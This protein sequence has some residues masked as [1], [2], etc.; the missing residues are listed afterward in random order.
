L[1]E[2]KKL[3]KIMLHIR[4]SH[5]NGHLNGEISLPGS[6][7]I[8]NRALVMA[9]LAQTQSVEINGLSTALDTVLMQANLA[10][11]GTGLF[12]AGDAGT[13]FRFLVARL[14]IC[15]GKHILQ[16]SD[17]MHERPIGPLV[18]ALR[19]L[20]IE[21]NYINQDGYPPIEIVGRKTETITVQQVELTGG[22]S[23]QF[24]SALLM[25]AP[26]LPHGLTLHVSEPRVSWAYVRMTIKMMRNWGIRIDESADGDIIV[27]AGAYQAEPIEVEPDWS[28]ASY[29][30]SMA[31]LSTSA[32]L[33]L[34]GLNLEQSVQ[35]DASMI[36]IFQRLGLVFTQEEQ[37]VRVN[38]LAEARLPRVLSQDFS[39]MPDI[40]QTLAVTCSALGISGVFSG[41]DTLKVKETDRI[42]AL[43]TELGKLGSSL[44]KMPSHMSKRSTSTQYMLDGKAEL[45]KEICIET[46]GDHRMAMAFA[47][48]ALLGA[49]E[50]H[51]PMV[52]TK[53]YP[54]F[55]KDLEALGF[56]V[57][58]I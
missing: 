50:I 9:S 51:E 36:P 27:G 44:V 2:A 41:L 15:E 7:S 8:S 52:V 48:L 14:A 55:W 21:I 19:Q 5:P 33:L 34:R 38:Q 25:I 4:L 26:L 13:V 45:P 12:D 54:N 31:V 58:T 32:H 42:K 17:R 43:K 23:S 30:C 24:I 40:A 37:G 53:S 6:K 46:Y 56:V 29:W 47:P 20:G 22:M 10:K 18:D 11:I 35:G 57:Q 1:P 49:I 39:D 3:N 16:G 28:A